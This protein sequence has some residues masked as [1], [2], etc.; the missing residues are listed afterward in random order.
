M[1]MDVYGTNPVIRRETANVEA[2][3]ILKHVGGHFDD[4]WY[5]KWNALSDKDK[6]KYS[7]ARQQHE[8]YNPGIYFRN[9]VWWWRPLWNYVWKLCEDDGVITREQYEEGHNNSGAEINV[10]QAELIALKLN[11][12]IKMGWVDEHKKQYE[13]DTKDDEHQYPFHEDNVKAFADFCH[14]SGGFSIQ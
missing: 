6:N 8:E 11:H 12:A 9:N 4:D 1:G 7:D 2:S 3:E 14:D 13:A 10:H 5:E